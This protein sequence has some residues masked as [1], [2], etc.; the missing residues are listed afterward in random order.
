[1]GPDSIN[2]SVKTLLFLQS[3]YHNKTVFHN[4]FGQILYDF[5]L[6]YYIKVLTHIAFNKLPLLRWL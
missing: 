2:K 6:K 3:D 1:M 4:T 5:R